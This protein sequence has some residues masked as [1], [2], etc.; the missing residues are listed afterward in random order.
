MALSMFRAKT[1]SGDKLKRYLRKQRRQL[2]E[3]DGATVEVGFLDQYIAN[4]ARSHEFGVR[5]RETGGPKL[6]AR[7]AF[8]QA[9]PEVRRDW[10]RSGRKL[11]RRMVRPRGASVHFDPKLAELAEEATRTVKRSYRQHRS[12]PLSR[13]QRERKRGTTGENKQ[14]TGHRGE[15]LIEHIEARHSEGRKIGG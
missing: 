4:I 8:R 3:L 11:A 1:T 5:D 13:I 6:P 9:L 2:R 14:L 12:K 15:K 10:R 7:P